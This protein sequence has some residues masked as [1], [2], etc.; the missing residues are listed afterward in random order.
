[1]KKYA[2]GGMPKT[3]RPIPMDAINPDALE[4]MGPPPPGRSMPKRKMTRE[5]IE[6]QMRKAGQMP[7]KRMEMNKEY[8]GKV[9][10]LASGGKVRGDGIC[11]KGKTKGRMV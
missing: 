4:G 8:S 6:E 1:M 9:K 3:R 10:R 11:R 7:P 2:D 5:E